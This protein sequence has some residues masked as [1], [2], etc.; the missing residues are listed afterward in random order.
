MK[1]AFIALIAC[2]LLVYGCG[3][4]NAKK[5]ETKKEQAVHSTVEKPQQP[6]QAAK[7]PETGEQPV[8]AAVEGT[9]LPAQQVAPAPPSQ[10]I[11]EAQQTG[12]ATQGRQPPCPMMVQQQGAVDLMKKISWSCPAVA[13]L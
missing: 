13:C 3:P 2:Y 12:E 11:T 6:T 10:P 9:Q 7:P 1:Y 4:D 5:T 8:A